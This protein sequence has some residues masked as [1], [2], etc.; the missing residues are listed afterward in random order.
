MRPYYYLHNINTQN[1]L[2]TN[3]V[4]NGGTDMDVE[5]QV[6]TYNDNEGSNFKRTFN[7]KGVGEQSLVEKP[8]ASRIGNTSN[9]RM[10]MRY[11][12]KYL[13]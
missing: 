3:P 6:T 12:Q 11:G 4:S 8:I 13:V 5:Y 1:E 7:L 10:E 9:V 2:P